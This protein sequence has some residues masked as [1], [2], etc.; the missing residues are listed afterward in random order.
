MEKTRE[1]KERLAQRCHEL[2]M[3]V[4]LLQEEKSNISAEYEHLQVYYFF[5]KY[6]EI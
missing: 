3:M 4:N 1:E 5:N 2:E 6:S